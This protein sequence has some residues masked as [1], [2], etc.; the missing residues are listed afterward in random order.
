[1]HS[2][3][4]SVKQY[5]ILRLLPAWKRYLPISTSLAAIWA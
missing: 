1:V 4:V 5:H 3:A 2:V